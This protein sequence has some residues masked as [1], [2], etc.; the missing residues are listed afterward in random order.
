MEK[1]EKDGVFDMS[2]NS[3]GW[4]KYIFGKRISIPRRVM[5]AG[6]FIFGNYFAFFHIW[7]IGN[8]Y[9]EYPH[10]IKDRA[11]IEGH[12]FPVITVCLNSMHSRK[13]LINLHP[14]LGIQPRGNEIKDNCSL[15]DFY[16]HNH[17]GL[18]HDLS[19]FD[20]I[21][22]DNFYNETYSAF[23]MISCKYKKDDCT[24]WWKRTLTLYG[25]CQV[26]DLAAMPNRAS[27][28]P[29]GFRSLQM[30]LAYNQSDW[31][32]GWN[33][34]MDGF[35]IFYNPEGET[36]LDPMRSITVNS[37]IVPIMFLQQH[38]NI[39]LGEPYTECTRNRSLQ[40][41]KQ[42]SKYNCNYECLIKE[43][44]K[45][46]KCRV[47]YF[48]KTTEYQV[49]MYHEH[50]R[51]VA[52]ILKEFMYSDCHCPVPCSE[53]FYKK[54]VYYTEMH[55]N[56][57]N[58]TAEMLKRFPDIALASVRI[59]LPEN[60]EMQHQEQA[61][62][63]ISQ[64]FS[65]VGGAMSLILGISLVSFL[66]LCELLWASSRMGWSYRKKIATKSRRSFQRVGPAMFDLAK[67]VKGTVGILTHLDSSTDSKESIIDKKVIV[68]TPSTD[69]WDKKATSG[70]SS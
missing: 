29:D 52:H 40:Y 1:I 44:Y 33:S 21:H 5:W 47:P 25:N 59:S 48:P 9:Y 12:S 41:F 51:C 22:L 56:F 8:R 7:R 27:I 57:R 68:F 66:E 35:S 3:C 30:V 67:S 64:L 18:T 36:V 69:R 19:L 24:K 65:D 13:K 43:V 10:S 20:H 38:R 70:R 53:L 58:K 6:V 16:G 4:L 61:D 23:L 2:T 15:W 31:T 37:R 54:T 46:C 26:L 14:E 28:S 55:Q 39:K 60:Y 42:Y 17:D 34:F 50:T 62:Y 11:K 49:C 45:R 32:Y 63:E